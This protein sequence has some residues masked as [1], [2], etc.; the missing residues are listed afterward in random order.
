[1]TEP[2]ASII[3]PLAQVIETVTG[4]APR[5]EGAGPASDGWMLRTRG[6]ETICGYGVACGGV[7]DADEWADLDSLRRLTGIYAR[8]IIQ[9][10]ERI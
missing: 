3:E 8:T 1:M 2:S 5:L 6:I 9:Y 4:T 7:H 10:L